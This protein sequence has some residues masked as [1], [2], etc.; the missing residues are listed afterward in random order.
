MTRRVSDYMQGESDEMRKKF[1]SE[2]RIRGASERGYVEIGGFLGFLVVIAVLLAL[3]PWAGMGGMGD[4]MGGGGMM[5]RG[6]DTSGA[7]VYEA[8]RSTTVVIDNYRYLPGNLRVPVGATVTWRNEDSAPHS[9]T[10]LG[11]GWDTGLLGKGSQASLLFDEPGDYI[12]YC[13][14][15]PEMKARIQVQ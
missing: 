6:R 2:Q 13:V 3:L 7:P 8:G 10:S 5:G 1:S 12:Y 14:A 4:M 15:H 11:Q 9:A